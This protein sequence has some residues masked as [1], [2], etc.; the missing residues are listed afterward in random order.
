MH[1]W[2]RVRCCRVASSGND[3]GGG[4]AGATSTSSR[5]RLPG[6]WAQ[7]RSTSGPCTD[8]RPGIGGAMAG[9][10]ILSIGVSPPFGLFHRLG[11]PMER[12]AFVHDLR[13]V[14][15]HIGREPAEDLDTSATP[16]RWPARACC[17]RRRRPRSGPRAGGPG[18]VPRPRRWPGCRAPAAVTGSENAWPAASLARMVTIPAG[19]PR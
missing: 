8:T 16:R 10:L 5:T 6:P 2:R 11:D 17:G 3:D 12:A 13:A 18:R 4:G 15:R 1:R 7:G 19:R 9:E 14:D